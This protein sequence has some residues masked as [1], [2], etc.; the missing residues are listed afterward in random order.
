MR[1]EA[2]R[3]QRGR[4]R[5]RIEARLTGLHH[6]ASDAAAQKIA[7]ANT[8]QARA[9]P[10]ARRIDGLTARQERRRINGHAGRPIGV[11]CTAP[12]RQRDP[13]PLCFRDGGGADAI[14]QRSALAWRGELDRHGQP[15]EQFRPL[16]RR[17]KR[18]RGNI[19]ALG[20]GQ[21]LHRQEAVDARRHCA[22]GADDIA[23]TP[24]LAAAHRAHSR[25][26]HGG[27]QLDAPDRI[28]R[29]RREGVGEWKSQMLDRY[30]GVGDGT[31]ELRQHTPRVAAYPATMNRRVLVAVL[32][33]SAWCFACAAPTLVAIAAFGTLTPMG[34]SDP[35]AGPFFDGDPADSGRFVAGQVA[36]RAFGVMAWAKLILAPIALVLLWRCTTHAPRWLIG[37]LI[38]AGVATAASHV[39]DTRTVALGAR[40]HDAVRAQDRSAASELHEDMTRLHPWAERLN[41]LASCSAVVAG[42][43]SIALAASER[44]TA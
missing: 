15:T 21:V 2:D 8:R 30:R 1:P 9:R 3:G 28:G 13:P 39:T 20:V 10:C 6:W 32:A 36:A 26:R 25:L 29:A 33:W 34:A 4:E 38:V 23:D 11:G 42:A 35:G 44:R 18:L 22:G 37:V 7:E 12:H 43:L 14:R 17:E 5:Q 16:D 31:H 41:G 40:W 19:H 27:G 24:P